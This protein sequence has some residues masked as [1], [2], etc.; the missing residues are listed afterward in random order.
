[1]KR[2]GNY[3]IVIFRMKWS[4]GISHYLEFTEF[5]KK[6]LKGNF[7]TSSSVYLEIHRSTYSISL[8]RDNVQS[9]VHYPKVIT[10]VLF[11]YSPLQYTMCCKMASVTFVWNK[12]VLVSCWSY[13]SC[14]S[15][16]KN[17]WAGLDFVHQELIGLLQE[18]R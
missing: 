15:N 12:R 1:M 14:F 9:E 5:Y 11:F 6:R 3:N 7:F 2:S 13:V 18:H 10:S 8:L 4:H 17:Y 16:E